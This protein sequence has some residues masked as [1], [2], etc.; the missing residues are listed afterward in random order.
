[1]Y[2][3]SHAHSLKTEISKHYS[4]ILSQS[5]KITRTQLFRNASVWET[6]WKGP[7]RLFGDVYTTVCVTPPYGYMHTPTMVPDGKKPFV[8]GLISGHSYVFVGI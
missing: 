5:K 1:M 8:S 7:P 2:L 6:Y 3:N 4:D